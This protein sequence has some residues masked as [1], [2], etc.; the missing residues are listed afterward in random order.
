[1]TTFNP[2]TNKI[3]YAPPE[4]NEWV[5]SKSVI[6]IFNIVEQ[7]NQTQLLKC[8]LDMGLDANMKNYQGTLL[9]RASKKGCADNVS[10]LLS[11]GANVNE[12]AY[13]NTGYT[14]LFCATESGCV[15][16]VRILLEAKADPNKICMPLNETPLEH[17]VRCSHFNFD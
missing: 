10:T 13:E 2:N 3:I 1:M 4:F 12:D 11:S 14:A 15:N 16:T 6:D 5:K 9:S 8:F 17:A 7:K